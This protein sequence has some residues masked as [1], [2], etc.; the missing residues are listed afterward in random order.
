MYVGDP[1]T[2]VPSMA[3]NGIIDFDSAYGDMSNSATTGAWWSVDLGGMY[4]VSK[5][6]SL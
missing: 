3:N 4:N 2:Y 1:T 6:F 5:C